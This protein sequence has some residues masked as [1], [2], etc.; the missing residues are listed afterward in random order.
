MIRALQ[1]RFHDIKP[2]PRASVLGQTRFDKW[3]KTFC[4]RN[5]F[6][7]ATTCQVAAAD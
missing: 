5:V 2:Y 3:H 1:H 7:D 6:I 4:H